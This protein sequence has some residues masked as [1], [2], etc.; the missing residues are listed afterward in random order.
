MV[1]IKIKIMALLIARAL[2]KMGYQI[3]VDSSMNHYRKVALK[4]TI[5]K[6]KTETIHMM[7]MTK[8]MM[9]I[10]NKR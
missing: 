5:S 2:M 9:I 4:T 8:K 7:K 3:E 10:L 6:S 1:L